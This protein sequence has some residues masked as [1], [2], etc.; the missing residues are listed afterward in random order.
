MTPEDGLI[1]PNGS[2]GDKAKLNCVSCLSSES[3]LKHRQLAQKPSQLKH[4]QWKCLTVRWSILWNEVYLQYGQMITL[5]SWWR[6]CW[7]VHNPRP[8]W[9][10]QWW[11]A[12]EKSFYWLTLANFPPS[13]IYVLQQTHEGQT[14]RPKLIWF[15]LALAWPPSPSQDKGWMHEPVI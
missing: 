11:T 13:L 2:L 15:D 3:K 10:K 9:I 4:R 8:S 7:T 14:V 12:D 6:L 5:R 1:L